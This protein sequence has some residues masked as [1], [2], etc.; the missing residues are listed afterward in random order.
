MREKFE[1]RVTVLPALELDN[2]FTIYTKLKLQ[3]NTI[4]NSTIYS[5]QELLK[6]SLLDLI[7]DE[8]KRSIKTE[9]SKYLRQSRDTTYLN[10]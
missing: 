10:K 5:N 4:Y 8:I 3:Q 2:C 9:L 7:F 1:V 6:E